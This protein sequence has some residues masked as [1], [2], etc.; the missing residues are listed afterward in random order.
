MRRLG[1]RRSA[2]LAALALLCVTPAVNADTVASL[3]GNFTINQF[4]GLTLEARTVNVHYVVV[5]GQLPALRELHAADADGNGVT[6]QR[7]R[8]Q[9]VGQL[10]P[11]LGADLDL[12]L[13]GVRLPL[14]AIRWSTS[15]PTEQGGFSLRADVDL[16]AALPA[17]PP[18]A[19]H[20]LRFSNTNYAG[21]LGWH[22]IVVKPGAGLAVFDTNAY[23]DSA[24]AGLTQAL[25]ALP[26]AG[27][28]DE[29]T[30]HFKFDAAALP[31]GAIPLGARGNAGLAATRGTANASSN[32]GAA[33]WIERHTRELVDSIS[34]QRLQWRVIVLALLAALI[35]GAVHALSPGH[36][37]TIVGAY[38]IGSRGTARHALFLAFTVTVTHTLGVFVLG[39]A[40][41]YAADFVEPARLFPILSLMSALLVLGMGFG[42]LIQR[43]RAA[44]AAL[45]PRQ[46]PG[47]P[48]YIAVQ[49]APGAHRWVLTGAHAML[50]DGTLHSHGGGPLHSHLPPGAAGERVTWKSLVA[51]GVSG[52]LVPC[53]SALVL[54]LAAIA[55]GKTAFGMVLVLV[56][57]LGLAA[58]LTAVGLIFIYARHRLGPPQPT[59]RW[60]YLV[61][62]L[63]AATITVI[64]AT[65]C[66][67]AWQ[68]FG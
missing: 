43:G 35:L 53:P 21:Q 32:G 25:Q 50:A 42:L 45:R 46:N 5:Y 31:A 34:G 62:V 19:V 60:P 27:P 2:W 52:G 7:E 39:F 22:E 58:T 1:Q 13:D 54:L 63:S 44:A 26:A 24:T 12:R 23:D 64:G 57:S 48:R 59:A 6:S 28:L 65:L 29:R 38:L 61:P 30:V 47:R 40:T 66:V 14:R 11:R 10:A 51:L 68:S 4:C 16:T 36:G 3:L 56:F 15:L 8:D 41:L 55:L 37:K 33:R 67:G 9:Y 17:A 18:G 49:P 20:E